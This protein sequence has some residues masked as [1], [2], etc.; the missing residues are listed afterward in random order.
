MATVADVRVK[1]GVDL[2]NF[3]RG[4]TNVTKGLD[5]VGK[6]MRATGKSLSLGLTAPILALGAKSIQLFDKQAKALAQ[7]ETAVRSTGGAAQLSVKQLTEQASALQRQ[8]IFGDEEILHPSN[9][10]RLT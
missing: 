3:N 8:T 4:M 9:S 10:I 2:Q 7:V 1:I 5:K 6:Q